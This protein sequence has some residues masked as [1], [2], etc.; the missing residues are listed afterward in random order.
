MMISH[1]LIEGGLYIAAG[2]FAGLMSGILGI[3]GGIVVV[4]A[5]LMIFQHNAAIPADSAMHIAVGTSL[6]IMIFTSQASVRAHYKH[7]DILWPIY[8][9]LAWGIAIGTLAGSILAVF[10][11]TEWLK[12]LLIIFLFVVAIKMFFDRDAIHPQRTPPRWVNAL[13]SFLIGLKSGLLG[14]GGGLLIIPYLT[15]SGVDIRKIAAVSAL[16]TMTVSLVGTM[17]FIITGLHV[18]DLPYGSLGY[19]YL[20]AVLCMA[21]PSSLAAPLGARLS[22][23]LS[24]K[25]LRYGFIVLLI[26]TA[27]N[28]IKS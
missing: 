4:P 1:M 3:G 12:I 11:P 22:Y 28:L 20:F 24:V 17:V 16:C 2:V 9:Q 13:V 7:G 8:K 10:I 21:I 25:Q 6:A 23:I 15:F 18:P 26:V 14:L 5:L 27:V 19:V